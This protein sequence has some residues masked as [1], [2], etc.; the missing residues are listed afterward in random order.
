[1]IL[2]WILL[3]ILFRILLRISQR[4]LLRI[5][6][7]ILRMISLMIL[8]CILRIARDERACKRPMRGQFSK[9]MGNTKKKYGLGSVALRI[10]NF[11]QA[12][13]PC[14]MGF[15]FWGG[16]G[17]KIWVLVGGFNFRLGTYNVPSGSSAPSLKTSA[18]REFD[19][20]G[21]TGWT[22]GTGGTVIKSVL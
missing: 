7:R 2:L 13:F 8:R 9:F 22:D 16:E 1:M 3:R 15:I 12:S 19:G 21:G 10:K 20:T 18:K 17:H 11:T 14:L 4:I 6:I 5:F